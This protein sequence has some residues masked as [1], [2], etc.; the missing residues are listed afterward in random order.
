MSLFKSIQKFFV[1]VQ[2]MCEHIPL[3]IDIY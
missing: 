3:A 2:C 1:Q